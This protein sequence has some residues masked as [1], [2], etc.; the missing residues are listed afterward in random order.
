V[1]DF[2]AEVKPSRTGDDGDAIAPVLA[3]SFLAGLPGLYQQITVMTDLTPTGSDSR[4][5]KTGRK[6]NGLLPQ[7]PFLVI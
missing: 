3:I 4:R 1:Y 5:W 7:F 2:L 6:A